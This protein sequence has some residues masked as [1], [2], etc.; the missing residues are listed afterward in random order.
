MEEYLAERIEVALRI[1][2]EWGGVDGDHHKAWTIDQIVRALTGCPT[3]IKAAK[4]F[5]GLPYSYEA[6]GESDE[7][8]AFVAGHNQGEDR[9]HTYQWN[10]GIAP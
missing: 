10:E 9:E 6:Q 5:R 3:V 7:Y 4:D 2:S 8:R 1:A